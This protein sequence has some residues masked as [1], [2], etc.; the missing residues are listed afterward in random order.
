MMLARN[1]SVSSKLPLEHFA[2]MNVRDIEQAPSWNT[3]ATMSTNL[4]SEQSHNAVLNT[5]IVRLDNSFFALI[6]ELKQMFV[7]NRHVNQSIQFL[8]YSHLRSQYFLGLGVINDASTGSN[9]N[10]GSSASGAK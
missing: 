4:P 7:L 5:V 10:F 1:L 2:V 6:V 3:T 8:I 9:S